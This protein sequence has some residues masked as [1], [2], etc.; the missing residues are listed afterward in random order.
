VELKGIQRQVGITFLFVTHDQEEALTMSDRIAVFSA[1]RIEQVG[2][3]AEVYEQP[4]TPFVAG[5]VGTS[6]LLRGDAAAQVLGREGT[7]SVRPEKIRIAALDAQPAADEDAAAGT[8]SEVV[9]V[10]SATRFLVDLDAGATLV[11]LQQNLQTSS[12]DV[13]GMRGSRVLLVWKKQHEFQVQPASP[14]LAHQ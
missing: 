11:A 5:F 4:A 8:V 12:M 7:W 2:S 13:Q 14:Q 9:Y 10:G 6:N 1:G 3:P